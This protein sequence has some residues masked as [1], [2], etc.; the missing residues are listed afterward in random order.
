[1]VGRPFLTHRSL[2]YKIL[3]ITTITSVGGR[4]L[5][6]NPSKLQ[7]PDIHFDA[8]LALVGVLLGFLFIVVIYLLEFPQEVLTTWGFPMVI[9]LAVCY[10]VGL[11]I[12]GFIL[13]FEINFYLANKITELEPNKVPQEKFIQLQRNMKQDLRRTVQM[14]LYFIFSFG[15]F[16]INL[17]GFAIENLRFGDDLFGIKQTQLRPIGAAPT[18]KIFRSKSSGRVRMIWIGIRY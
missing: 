11:S 13:R 10:G 5:T 16:L 2:H 15:L 1:M 3:N 7:R 4:F 9:F 8:I 17:A 14:L 12:I 18:I 6:A